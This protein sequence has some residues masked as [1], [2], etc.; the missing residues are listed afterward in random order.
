[1]AEQDLTVKVTIDFDETQFA[2]LEH[3]I[4][5]LLSLSQALPP[6]SRDSLDRWM[7]RVLRNGDAPLDEIVT[8]LDLGQ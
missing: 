7:G 8:A 4:E 2:R 1:M 3:I 5:Q 6:R